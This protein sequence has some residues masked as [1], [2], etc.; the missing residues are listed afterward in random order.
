VA[1]NF[2]FPGAA[3]RTAVIGATGTGKTILGAWLLSK[4]R[5][6]KRPWVII[7]FKG[8]E[9]WDRVGTPPLRK[10]KLGQMPG[11]RGLYIMSVLPGQDD[12]LE[13]WLWSIWKR[14]DVGLF[15]DEV[16]L[17]PQK[18]AFKAIL[19]Q[20]RSKLIPVISC[21]QRPVDV[22]REVWSEANYI[23]VFRLDD[24]RDYKII[25]GFT[26]DAP[27]DRQLP[28]YHSHWYDKKK[29]TCIELQP[30]PSPVIIAD[31]LKRVA[32]RPVSFL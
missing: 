1:S 3:D 8:E 24:I 29:Y 5:F 26:R 32:P 28:E 14:G 9:L 2:T 27:I 20:G 21:S 31:D 17:M 6:D 10:L 16:S 19:R 30:V 23:S 22:D 7:D 25:K 12:E 13:K 4:Q 18:E 11:K 15:I